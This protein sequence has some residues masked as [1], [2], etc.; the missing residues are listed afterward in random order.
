MLGFTRLLF[1]DAQQLA[2]FFIE[3]ASSR[4]V[5]LHPFSVDHKL[6]NS[7]FAHVFQQFVNS[8]GSVLDIHFIKRDVVLREK[9]LSLT[10]IAAPERGVNGQVHLSMVSRCRLTRA[11]EV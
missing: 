6:G 8:A 3:K 10:A 7:P 2:H 9:V 5:R 11:S 4:T 1:L